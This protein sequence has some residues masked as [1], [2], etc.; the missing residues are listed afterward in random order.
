L[1]VFGSFVCSLALFLNPGLQGTIT[2]FDWI[3]AGSINIPVSFL[4]DHISVVMLLIITG[5]GFLIH[6]YSIGYM[7][8]DEAFPRFFAHLNLFVFFM[9]ILVLGAN[10]LMMFIGWEGVG[11]CSYLLIG[12]WFKNT[13]YNRA[14]NKAFIM[15]RIGDLGFLM[16]MILIFVTFGSF[17]YQEVFS[18]AAGMQANTPVLIAITLL[19]FVGAMGKSAQIP[20]YTWLPMQWPDQ[21]LFLR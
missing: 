17:N 2:L 9:L 10:Y 7:H 21:H 5:V 8:D 14:A 16:G 13:E 6:V 1:Q 3:R 18:A 12:Y 20:L 4:V 15:N 19:L 11:L